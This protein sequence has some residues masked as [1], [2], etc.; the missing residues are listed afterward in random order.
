MNH[1]VKF[2][3]KRLGSYRGVLP[4]QTLKTLKGQALS[5]DVEGAKK[6]L[7]KKLEEVRK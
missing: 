3:I 6:G 4:R 7:Q 5:G 2:F 1:D